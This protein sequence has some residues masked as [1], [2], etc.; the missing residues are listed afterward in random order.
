MRDDRTG[1]RALTEAV[2][3]FA[4]L[5]DDAAAVAAQVAG[6]SQQRLAAARASFT[7]FGT[8]SVAQPR[9]DLIRLGLL[10]GPVAA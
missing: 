2:G 9:D 1:G 8:C 10:P 5:L 3:D 4:A 7:S 6:L